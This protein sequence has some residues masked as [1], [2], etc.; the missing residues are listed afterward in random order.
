MIV[1]EQV[2]TSKNQQR[3]TTWK[4]SQLL[5]NL[6]WICIYNLSIKYFEWAK[7][8]KQ[9]WTGK[10]NIGITFCVIFDS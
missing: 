2:K 9:K 10:E 8:I 1:L 6:S 3:K 5:K 7:E 4:Q